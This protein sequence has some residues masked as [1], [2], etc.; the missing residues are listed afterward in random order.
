ME[1]LKIGID[2]MHCDACVRRVQ[3]ALDKVPGVRVRA[4]NIGEAEVEASESEKET[5]VA[6]IRKAG[7]T[8]R[9]GE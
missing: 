6:A 9:S 3:M 7:Y 5:V 1:T 8:P 2:G 4:V